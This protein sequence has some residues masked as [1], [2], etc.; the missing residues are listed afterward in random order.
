MCVCVWCHVLFHEHIYSDVFC[1]V[2]RAL[3]VCVVCLV[4]A[5]RV[6]VVACAFVCVFVCELL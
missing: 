1:C 2:L 3:S 6:C 4:C 5:V